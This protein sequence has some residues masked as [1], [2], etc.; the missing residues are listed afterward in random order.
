MKIGITLGLT[1]EY[2]SLWLNGIKLNILNLAKTLMEIPEYEVFL[3]DT[4]N[5]VTDLTKVSW[6]YN[7]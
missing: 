7:K 3:L 4:S 2:E 5:V 1:K 6:D